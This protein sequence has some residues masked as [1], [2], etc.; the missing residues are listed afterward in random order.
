MTLPLAGGRPRSIFPLLHPTV[1]SAGADDIQ[2][3]GQEDR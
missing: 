2:P 1:R 3:N